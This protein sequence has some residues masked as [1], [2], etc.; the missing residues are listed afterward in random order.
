[1]RRHFEVV[2]RICA[3]ETI[4]VGERIREIKRLRRFYGSGRWRKL[5]GVASIRL[6][7]GTIRKAEVHWY[8]TSGIGRKE[9][10][11]KYFVD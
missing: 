1:M 10:K 6:A 3:V 5:K 9:L 7:D 11:I 4:A 2:G 8:E